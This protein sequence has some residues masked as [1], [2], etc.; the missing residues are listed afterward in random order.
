MK[1]SLDTSAGS[2][3][4][5]H[6]DVRIVLAAR[7]V[8]FLGDAV[9]V[10]ALTVHVARD[11]DPVRLALLL[12]AFGLPVVA[13]AGAA[14]R[15]V[16]TR[17]SRLLLVVAGLVQ[18]CA[19][20]ALAFATS[21]GAILL[22]VVLLQCGQAVMAPTW[23]ALLPE[24]VGEDLVARA[25]G[26]QGTLG[27]LADLVGF[28]VGGI[29][30][31]RLGLRA[32]LLLDAATFLL[33]VGAACLVKTRRR[34]SLTRSPSPGLDPPTHAG[35][36]HLI[37]ADPVLRL[38]VP[39]LL[40]FVVAAEATN[41]VEALLVTRTLGGDGTA[42]GLVAA[43]FG[44]GAVVGPALAARVTRERSRIVSIA[45]SEAMVG[46]ALITLGLAPTVSWLLLPSVLAGLGSGLFNA[47][48]LSL[49]T[50]RAPREARGRILA[51]V[52]G[53]TRAVSMLALVTGG[54]AGSAFGPRAVFIGCG[55][56]TLV[57]APLALIAVR[58]SGQPLPPMPGSVP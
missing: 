17:D 50:L 7:A 5:D 31:D 47:A 18:T 2:R 8:S 49:I 37:R 29:L 19:A 43:V 56:A 3:L 1:Q 6:P 51:T 41:V 34:P 45:A 54:V 32:A 27:A 15:L 4:R 36:L 35:G 44:A 58:G 23:G 48:S 40:V 57:L 39:T 30:F 9:A 55:L 42:Y 24:I 52:M 28:P 21:L 16:D 25:I 38:L 22:F 26:L 13:V 12:A 53:A 14:G 20:V 10:A 33:L 46:L 11:D